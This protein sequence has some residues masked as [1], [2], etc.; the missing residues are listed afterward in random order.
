MWNYSD[1]ERPVRWGKGNHDP[2]TAEVIE[3]QKDLLSSQK[4]RLNQS[5]VP[6]CKTHLSRPQ[7]QAFLYCPP[8]IPSGVEEPP[9]YTDDPGS[10][11]TSLA[12]RCLH[13]GKH[14]QCLLSI[15]M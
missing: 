7:S 2:V 15:Y 9:G 11:A 6:C 3:G 13:Y 5:T 14:A 8:S 1:T 12:G 4:E 10:P